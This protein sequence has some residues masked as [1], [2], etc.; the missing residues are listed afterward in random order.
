[1]TDF[2]ITRDGAQARVKL[3]MRLTAAVAPALHPALRQEIAAGVREVIF[4]LSDTASLD[5]TGI[6]LLI[7]TNNSLALAQGTVRMV[8]VSPD[9]LKLL[10]SMRLVERLHVSGKTEGF[11]G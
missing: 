2:Q 11:N 5:S 4:D 9:I 10:R 8:N 7:A 3:G 6:G 1:M